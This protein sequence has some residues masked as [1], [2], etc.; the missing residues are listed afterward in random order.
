M[1][2]VVIASRDVPQLLFDPGEGEDTYLFVTDDRPLAR[3]ARR[4]GFRTATGDLA[5]ASLYRRVAIS[6]QDRILVYLPHP[7]RLNRCL[8]KLLTIDSEVPVT[9]LLDPGSEPPERWKDEVLYLPSQR[10]GSVCLRSEME[11]AA[12]RRALAAI[13]TLFRGAE[14]IL[15]LV[16]DDPDPDGLASALALR[17]LLGRNRLSTVIG[18]FGEVK[19]PENIAMVRL[20]DI[21]VQKITAEDLRGFDR[22]ALLDVQPFHSP[23]IPTQVDLV[24]DHHPRRTNFTAKIRDIRPRYGATSTIMTEYLLAADMTV[25]QRLA[26]ALLY[27]IKTDTQLLGRDTTPM[28][29]AA[30]SALYPLASHGLLRRID[31]PQFPRRDLATLSLALQN[32]HILDD[33]LFVHMGPLTRED[34]IPYIADF[35]LEVEAV[36]W[37]VV[38]GL[39]EGKLIVSVRNYC[40]GRHA[41]EVM[42]AAFEAY[43]SAGGHKAMAK[44]V[45]PLD[46]IPLDCLDHESWVRDRFLVAL[47]ER[48][49]KGC[50]EEERAAR[51]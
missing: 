1:R 14:R 12:T 26:T 8:S 33:I 32:A 7:A 11:K 9:V 2:I 5:S 19:R 37:S 42:K 30:F 49:G 41:G 17:A 24:I 25:S 10:L 40:A 43:G 50:T 45:I 35:C 48:P 28:D 39:S 31:R 29:V 22:L 3:K 20:L 27:G 21:Q 34:V 46:Q 6:G 36:E 15:L 23:D 16:Q 47:Y 13:R 51:G 4:R 38:S 44:A 18:S